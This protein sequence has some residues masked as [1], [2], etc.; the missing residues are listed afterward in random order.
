MSTITVSN[1]GK[2]YK[3]YPSRWSRLAEWLLPFGKPRHQL[4]WVLQDISFKVNP[5]EAVGI[6]GINGAGKSTL[7]KMITGTTQPTTGNVNITG[8]VAALLELGMGFHPDFTGRQN[9]FMA[10]QL[11]GMSVEEISGLMPEIETFSGIGDYIDQ[12]LRVFSSGMQVRLAFSVATARRPDILIID[13]ALAVGDVFFQ[14]KCF[15]RIRRYRKYGTTLLFVSHSMQSVY[16]LCDRALLIDAGSV[17]LNDKPKAVIDLYNARVIQRMNP[18]P[19]ALRVAKQLTSAQSK[20]GDKRASDAPTIANDQNAQIN[21]IG[22]YATEEAEISEVN[23]YV[24][25]RAVKTFVS[26]S[27]ATVHVK[28]LFNRSCADPH[29]GFQIRNNLGEDVFMT[30]TYAMKKSIGPV[31]VASIVEVKFSFKASLAEGQYTLTVGVANEGLFD[32]QFK[33]SLA[34]IQNAHAFSVLRN[35]ESIGWA[36]VYNLSPTCEIHVEPNVHRELGGS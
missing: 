20:S 10:G 21:G 19:N 28:V 5:G 6:I 26:D 1:L 13:E 14:Q 36:G 2:A 15:D 33:E 34:R 3:Q 24:E 4:K 9:V 29:V 16:S 8:R 35:P 23:L 17:A 11:L 27:V 18:D 31:R 32:G 7:L 22:S 30:N 25:G 12:P